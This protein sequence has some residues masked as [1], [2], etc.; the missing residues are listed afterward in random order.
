MHKHA[1]ASELHQSAIMRH[2]P[3]LSSCGC[4]VLALASSDHDRSK[5]MTLSMRWGRCYVCRW[6]P[7]R[8]SID[9]VILGG[10]Y[11]IC[12]KTSDWMRCTDVFSG[13][14]SVT[15]LIVRSIGTRSTVDS[16]PAHRW[17]C[18]KASLSG[19][20][21]PCDDRMALSD[22][23]V[24]PRHSLTIIWHSAT[25]VRYPGIAVSE[26]VSNV[27]A[28]C[29]HTCHQWV[30]ASPEITLTVR[31]LRNRVAK[32]RGWLDTNKLHTHSVQI[33]HRLLKMIRDHNNCLYSMVMVFT[34]IGMHGT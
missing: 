15:L 9:E 24:T 22:G 13:R 11:V 14:V 16:P 2:P 27:I 1:G 7:S 30:G 21:R 31:T 19:K 4:D 32:T 23:Q 18:T 28:Q 34:L 25:A 26:A 5:L 10:Q 12:G 3:Q 17:Y 33:W 29:A 6:C 20:G 8:Y